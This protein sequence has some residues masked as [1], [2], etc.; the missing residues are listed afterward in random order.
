MTAPAIGLC[1]ASAGV[2]W[3]RVARARRHGWI[4]E[5]AFAEAM[6]AAVVFTAA[7]VLASPEAAGSPR[8]STQRL[9]PRP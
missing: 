5:A 8:T 7:S 1:A 4:G 3:M 9:G 2:H 6:H